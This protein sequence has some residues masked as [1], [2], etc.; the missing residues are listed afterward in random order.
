MPFFETKDHTQ[1]FYVDA[2][3]GTPIVF[4]VVR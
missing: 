3:A 4:V 2:V 1:L